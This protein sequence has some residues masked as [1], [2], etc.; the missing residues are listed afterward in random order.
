MLTAQGKR[1]DWIRLSQKYHLNCRK[2]A[3]HMARLDDPT[4]LIR[5]QQTRVWR[6]TPNNLFKSKIKN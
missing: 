3:N 6:K 1:D 2:S 5:D 4:Q